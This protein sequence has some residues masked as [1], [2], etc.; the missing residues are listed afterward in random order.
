[1]KASKLPEVRRGRR[2]DDASR[3][4]QAVVDRLTENNLAEIRPAE[5]GAWRVETAAA[6]IG[7]KTSTVYNEVSLAN[8]GRS[9]LGIPFIKIGR[10]VRFRK[11]DL[12]GWL[13]ERAAGNAGT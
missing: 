9:R 7:L 2:P 3:I 4:A 10:A 6:Y 5:A 1:M 8:R 13:A 11:I 12:D